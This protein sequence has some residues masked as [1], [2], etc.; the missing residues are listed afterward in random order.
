MQF[1]PKGYV[2]EDTSK[3][4]IWFSVRCG[5]GRSYNVLLQPYGCY[6]VFTDGWRELVF[7]ECIKQG[8]IGFF[9]RIGALELDLILHDN[10][11]VQKHHPPQPEATRLQKNG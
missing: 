6:Q 8:D 11:G 10:Q 5:V 2:L 3:G 7:A 1:I 9:K 4:K